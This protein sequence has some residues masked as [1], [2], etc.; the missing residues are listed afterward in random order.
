ME[1]VRKYEFWEDIGTA[2]F[3]S[4]KKNGDVVVVR[5]DED[6]CQIPEI[7]NTILKIE[8]DLRVFYEKNQ[9]RKK[10][11]DSDKYE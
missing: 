6:A 3:V 9:R 11:K 1:C 4:L 5:K 8:E 2:A 7:A 10:R